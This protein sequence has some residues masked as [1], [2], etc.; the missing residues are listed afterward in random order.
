MTRPRSEGRCSRSDRASPRSG[1][2]RRRRTSG[3]GLGR[4]LRTPSLADR[5][6]RGCRVLPDGGVPGGLLAAR[7]G[8]G[9]WQRPAEQGT[10]C[11]YVLRP[12]LALHRLSR[13]RDGG[14]VYRMKR[15]RVVDADAGGAVG[16][17]GDAH[18]AAAGTR[19]AVPRGVGLPLQ[20]AQARRAGGRRRARAR[21]APS[22]SPPTVRAVSWP[23][24]FEQAPALPPVRTYR[25]PWAQLLKKVFAIDVLACPECSGRLKMTAFIEDH[26]QRL[27]QQL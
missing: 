11:R 25:V 27:L 19:G 13:S 12:P 21:P 15:P 3:S 5:E 16:E 2:P 24:P 22:A 20:D 17:A 9:A 23:P 10:A 6:E 4:A 18:S 14:F 26:L 8:P 1:S 7:R